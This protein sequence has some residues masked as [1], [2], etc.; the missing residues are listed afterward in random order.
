MALTEADATTDLF[1]GHPGGAFSKVFRW[2]FE[3]QG[4]YQPAGAPSPV[5]Q[6]G[7]P[8]SVDVYIDDG[9]LGE[10][11]PYLG[12]LSQGLPRSGTERPLMAGPIT[13]LQ[14]LGSRTSPMSV[15]VIGGPGR[16]PVS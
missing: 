5:K 7:G 10:Y 9:R 4:L 1:E 15:S 11:M 3:K 16:P 2:S 14:P 8:P 6:P 12:R 13:N